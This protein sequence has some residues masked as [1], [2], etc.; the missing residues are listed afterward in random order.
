MPELHLK[1]LA[2]GSIVNDHIRVVYLTSTGNLIKK[3]DIKCFL[4][5]KQ[6]VLGFK[7]FPL[8][9]YILELKNK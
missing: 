4:G 9:I 2:H 8:K 7:K 1:L 5:Q 3:T 6:G